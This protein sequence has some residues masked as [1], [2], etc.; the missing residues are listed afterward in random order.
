MKTSLRRRLATLLGSAT[1]AGSLLATV[2]A[3]G[4]ALG[5]DAG[6]TAL[7]GVDAAG[8]CTVSAAKA[9]SGTITVSE[10]LVL[11]SGGRLDASAS[12]V[13]LTVTGNMSMASGSF[14][15]ADDNNVPT[16]GRHAAPA[17]SS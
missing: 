2:V 8:T 12:G 16:R 10:N 17:T 9:V 4:V 13:T 7:G 11:T 15:E 5:A 3:P 1:I 14:I 6:C